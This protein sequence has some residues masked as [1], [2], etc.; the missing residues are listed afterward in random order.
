MHTALSHSPGSSV[1]TGIHQHRQNQQAEPGS[2]PPGSI[3]SYQQICSQYRKLILAGSQLL[4]LLP[5]ACS[6]SQGDPDWWGTKCHRGEEHPW[7]ETKAAALPQTLPWFPFLVPRKHHAGCCSN[8]VCAVP[9]G[10]SSSWGAAATGT[11]SA[12][13]LLIV[14]EPSAV[15]WDPAPLSS[16]PSF[17]PRLYHCTTHTL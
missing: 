15:L 13:I 3:S 8:S 17:S 11:A 1:L 2:A 4:L 6:C 5:A 10:T 16:K 14:H 7:R 12:S 9:V